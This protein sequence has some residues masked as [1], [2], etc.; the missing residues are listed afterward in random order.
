MTY[1]SILALT[2]FSTSAERA[3]DRAA[4]LAARHRSSLR[5]MYADEVPIL[6][7]SDP[8]A[9]LQQRARQLA[10]RHGIVAE[11]L[12]HSGDMVDAIV[13]HAAHT[14]LLVL[15][16]RQHR[17]WHAFWLG[18][19]LD[20]LVRRSPCPVLVVKQAPSGPYARL[21]FALEAASGSKKLVRYGGDFAGEAEFELSGGLKTFKEA[22]TRSDSNS[23]SAET[24]ETYRQ[25]VLQDTHVRCIRFS[26]SMGPRKSWASL[27]DR[28]F[29]PACRIAVH[30]EVK[31]S[32]LVIV[33]KPKNSV[34]ADFLRG[35]IARRIVSFAVCDVLVV[36]HDHKTPSG[37]AARR[38]MQ[39]L[40]NEEAGQL[41][42]T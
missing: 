32:D 23:G 6:R 33:I 41:Q 4:L 15:D 24:M 40:L 25:A 2:D 37:T 22:G 29:E 11:A 10:R 18:T 26:D 36:R 30:E 7:F 42:H 21:L 14:D 17:P 12:A 1:Q 9:R 5:I 3:L 20:Q 38:R 34:L 28:C 27:I 31:C 39:S 19:T 16:H 13:Q 35:S 8:F